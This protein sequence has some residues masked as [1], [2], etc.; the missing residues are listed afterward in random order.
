MGVEMD[1]ARVCQHSEHTFAGIRDSRYG[2]VCLVHG[3]QK[4][5]SDS[6][7]ATESNDT[8]Q[9]LSMLGRAG[10]VCIC[11]RLAHQNAVVTLFNLFQ[12]IFVVITGDR[13]VTTVNDSSPS[14]ERVRLKSSQRGTAA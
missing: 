1:D 6:V 11:G 7:V 12:S 9:C 14:I 13:N 2:S 3:A 4:R 10:H 8:R 5:Q